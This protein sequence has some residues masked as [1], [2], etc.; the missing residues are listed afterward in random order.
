MV[1]VSRVGVGVKT[2][3]NRFKNCMEGRFGETDS[4]GFS[5]GNTQGR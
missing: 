5:G 4:S 1:W 3:I 2:E